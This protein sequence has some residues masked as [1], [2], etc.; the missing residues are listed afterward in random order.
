MGETRAKLCLFFQ[1]PHV[2]IRH[3]I[4]LSFFKNILSSSSWW[5]VCLSH[6]KRVRLVSKTDLPSD[7]VCGV[8]TGINGPHD[9]KLSCG[10]LTFL[11]WFFFF[12]VTVLFHWTPKQG[13]QNSIY[14]GNPKLPGHAR[15]KA[16]SKMTFES[17]VSM[18][19]QLKPRG[20][21]YTFSRPFG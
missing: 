16:E 2:V 20:F 6:I 8:K 5:L 17:P 11:E 7:M 3:F 12:P 9:L 19:Q 18:K 15:P 14:K 4:I 1:R 13:I 10:M 21:F